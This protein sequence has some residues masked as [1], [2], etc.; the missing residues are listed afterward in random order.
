MIILPIV[1]A[2]YLLYPTYQFY[3]LDQERQSVANDSAALEEWDASHDEEYESAKQKRIKLGLDLRGGMYVTL[4]V[5]VMKLIEESADPLS[6]DEDF[7]A[8]VEKTRKRTD[9][10]DLD[11]LDTFLEIFRASNQSL[12]QYFTVS[13]QLDP[14]EKA[15]E[16][17]LRRDV[18]DAVDQALQV[19]KQRID[20]YAISEVN[21]Q[22]QGVRRILLEMPDV[23]DETEIRKLLQTTARLEFKRVLP[24]RKMIDAFYTIDSYMK[25]GK[26]AET[27]DTAA[28]D[29]SAMAS[30]EKKDSTKTD[31]STVKKDSA[32]KDT[33][34]PYA[35]LSD[36]EALKAIKRDYPFTYMVS[37]L[38]AP[39]EQTNFQAFD[40]TLKTP[41]DFPEQGIYRFVVSEDNLQKMLTILDRPD[42]AKLIPMDMQ[43][44]V[45]AKA[46]GGGRDNPD[47]PK[48]YDIYAVS[49]EAELTG[50]VITDAYPSFDPT[51]NTPV[52]HMEMNSMGAERWAQITGANIG[53][54]IAIV[55]DDR[56]YSAPNVINKI[57]NGS[58]QITGM[59]NAE[60]SSL[61][62]VVLKAGALKAPVKIIEERVIGPSLGEDSIRRGVISSVFSFAL[63]ILFMLIY[64]M[65]GGGLADIALMMNVLLV[66][67]GLAA[68]GGTLTLPGIA[69]IILSTAMA[70][71]A[72]IL[73]F[74]RIREEMAAG[75]ALRA[76][77]EQ[78]YAKAWSAIL[79]SNV[80]NMLSGL[81]L[82]FLGS[83]P[84]KGFAVTLIIGVLM[85]L[86]TAVV[87]TRAMF[88]LIINSGA[89]SINLGQP[90]ASA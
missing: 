19:I 71:D 66:I 61:L 39:N 54:Q 21:I 77:V 35:G 53:K 83:G 26:V 5:D 78:G 48:F 64:Y 67:A 20:K 30:N 8:I 81:V 18:D 75:R 65:M 33:T 41:S 4:E 74:E 51:N 82:I 73:I 7:I 59:A 11:V 29:T 6:V 31:S 9:N 84:V 63:V 85:T 58:S 22:K 2:G 56:V 72:N 12:L 57:P 27:V 90:K 24:G 28:A 76:A 80:T 55:L 16:E 44:L 42:V 14:T 70:V 87:V 88:E 49:S 47:A 69:G 32:K 89:T 46:Q 50:D 13:N 10:T 38:F 1:A 15:I 34:N 60:E 52:V 17:K 68:F 86:F 62:A 23:K 25:G 36:D 40:F 45:G 79:D 3:M 37:G 43:I